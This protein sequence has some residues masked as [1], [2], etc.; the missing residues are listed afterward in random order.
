MRNKAMMIQACPLKRAASAFGTPSPLSALA[1]RGIR[2]NG[3]LHG[4]S[5][6]SGMLTN[7]ASPCSASGGTSKSM[8]DISKVPASCV[9]PLARRW[10]GTPPALLAP[11][12]AATTTSGM[13]SCGSFHGLGVEPDTLTSHVSPGRAPSGTNMRTLESSSSPTPA[14][15]YSCQPSLHPCLPAGKA[16]SRPGVLASAAALVAHQSHVRNAATATALAAST[17]PT[18]RE[19]WKRR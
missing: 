5:V 6:K 18:S 11:S 2:T 19:Q 7:H 17:P 14:C 16:A 15:S 10:R 1:R 12:C 3:S 8:L 9:P 4:R 13:T